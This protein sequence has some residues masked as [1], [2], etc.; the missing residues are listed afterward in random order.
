MSLLDALPH[1]CKIVRRVRTADVLGGGKDGETVE[2]TDVECWEQ[3]AS[4][5]EITEFGKRGINVSR[6]IFFV[7]DPGVTER[8]QI[9]ITSRLGVL[10]PAASQLSLD[11]KS[12]T[13]PDASAG[14]AIL[15]KVMTGDSTGEIT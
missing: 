4:A 14:L 6:K 15:W 8:H 9:I 1:R 13:R 12:D 5:S 11:V 3:Q 7:E 2:Q 10:V